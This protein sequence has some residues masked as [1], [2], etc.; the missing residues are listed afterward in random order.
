MGKTITLTESELI[1]II[2][3]IML[4]SPMISEVKKVEN[5]DEYSPEY[6]YTSIGF[7]S[8]PKYPNVFNN[9]YFNIAK[10]EQ[11]EYLPPERNV[12]IT[13]TGPKG[14][15]TFESGKVNRASS[16]SPYV[17]RYD[18]NDDYY[19]RLLN[20]FQPITTTPTDNVDKPSS[21]FTGQEIKDALEMAF[22]NNWNAETD[23]YSAGVR[24]VYTIGERDNTDEDWSIMNYFDTKSE[25]KKLINEKW[26]N[27]GSGDKVKWLSSV[28]Q[29]DDEFLKKILDIQW[30][31]I[32]GGFKTEERGLKNLIKM[33]ES[34]GKRFNYEVY[35]PGHKTDR[36]KSI[37]LKLQI[38]NEPPMTIQIKPL[39][40]LEKSKKRDNEY[41][42]YTYGMNN[43]YRNKKGLDYILYNKG[44]GFIIF[45]NR[46]YYV[47]D[48][49]NEVIHYT[50]PYEVYNI[51]LN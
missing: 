9:V 2:Q 37:D 21:E 32:K 23:D 43:Y 4:D 8:N 35:P 3:K 11:N 20:L 41:K 28:F 50:E 16:G 34:S 42:V 17:R 38:E 6:E 15:F 13:F 12:M 27:E 40:K 7:T 46:Q 36:F 48:S 30:N 51:N 39:T 1:N 19:N 24:G 45:N 31:S 10:G 26:N 25:V 47:S 18:L 22:P 44:D 29:N 49:G 33:L 5:F 14:D